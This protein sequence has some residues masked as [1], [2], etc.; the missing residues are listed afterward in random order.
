ML[1]IYGV[2]ISV[3]TR[4]VIVVAIAKDLPHEVVPDLERLSPEPALYPQPAREY[5]LALC[6]EQYAGALFREVVHPLF[7]E[8]VVHPKMRDVATDQKRVDDV[9]N[10][11]MPETFGYLDS[12][13]G[14][15]FLAGKFMS[16]ADIA[17]ASN[18][19]NYQY[20]G[21]DLDRRRFPSLAALYDRT[22]RQPAM[23]EALRREEPV[24]ASMGLRDDFLRASLS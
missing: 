9:L 16:I 3:H 22:V 23:R 10:R 24:V 11:A 17:V 1:K 21:F 4:K 20:I 12:V 18:L 7:Q 6:L 8:T 15:C 14:E 2:P 13:A 5:A 19:T